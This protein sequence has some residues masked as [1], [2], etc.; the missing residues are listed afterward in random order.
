MSFTNPKPAGYAIG[1]KLPS[2]HVNTVWANVALAFDPTA[3]GTWNNNGTPAIINVPAGG[4]IGIGPSVGNTGTYLQLGAFLLLRAASGDIVGPMTITDLGP[5]IGSV[6]WAGGK[7][8]QVNARSIIYEQ[9]LIPF[10]KSTE[11]TGPHVTA[12]AFD[13]TNVGSAGDLVFPITHRPSHGNLQA[14]T[15][16]ID[17]NGVGGAH[18]S[19]PATMPRA[20]VEYINTTAS[21]TSGTYATD[22]SANVATYDAAHAITALA[23]AFIPTDESFIAYVRIQGETG[24]NSLASALRVFRVTA[25]FTVTEIAA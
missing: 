20:R 9:P 4:L 25:T 19:L 18:S 17:G 12:L 5:A 21:V 6:T 7:W 8:P 24:A 10:I 22:S 14:V 3:G 2:G 11:W 23:P 1:E 15:V 16:Y 13:Q